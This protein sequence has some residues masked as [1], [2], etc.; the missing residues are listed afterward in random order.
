M[1]GFLEVE[2]LLV[3][4]LDARPLQVGLLEEGVL[5]RL[6]PL[7]LAFG[8]LHSLHHGPRRRGQLLELRVRFTG[9]SLRTGNLRTERSKFPRAVG[10]GGGG[11]R[12]RR[13]RRGGVGGHRGGGDGRGIVAG[14]SGGHC[15]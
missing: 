8:L 7:V 4:R 6:H 15:G 14:D 11:N 3:E 5:R 1:E 10:G 2:F 9:S 12:R 13:C